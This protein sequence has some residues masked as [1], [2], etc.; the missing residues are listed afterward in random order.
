MQT[1]DRYPS[2]WTELV[3]LAKRIPDGETCAAIALAN[4]RESKS[5][6]EALEWILLAMLATQTDELQTLRKWL[7]VRAGA[8]RH[9]EQTNGM[10]ARVSIASAVEAVSD[11][12]AE[13][14]FAP[15]AGASLERVKNLFKRIAGRSLPN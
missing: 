10:Q 15:R 14:F 1:K 8:I 4:V 3:D 6:E 7:N 2:E 5:D 12:I 13:L 9:E 11:T